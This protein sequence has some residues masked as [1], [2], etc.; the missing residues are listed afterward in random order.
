[1][2]QTLEFLAEIELGIYLLLGLLAVVYFR[3]LMLSY[4]A[5]RHSIFGLEKE[6]AQRKFI[7]S[8]TILVLVTAMAFSVF[9]LVT[10]V[11][12]GL[13]DP[14]EGDPAALQ[15][16]LDG[17]PSATQSLDAT[18]D[19]LLLNTA[20]TA[21]PEQ[22]ALISNCVVGELEI[23]SPQPE[24]TVRGVVEIKGTVNPSNFGSYKYEYSTTG[25]LQW[26]TIA[27]GNEIVID[28]SLGFWYT[29]S[30]IP[31]DYYLRVVP[32]DNQGVALTPCV[33]HVFVESSD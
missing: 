12:P 26:K 21:I 32:L 2:K 25:I 13:P 8:T 29:N 5:W 10:F 17:T 1:M 3:Q 31:G 33:I 27:A 6:I 19:I 18:Q 23:T 30:L 4:H 22:Q 11:L 20:E 16:G 28:A 15:V 14:Y 7:A 9:I 24:E